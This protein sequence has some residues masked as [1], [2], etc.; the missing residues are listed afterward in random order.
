[1]VA[2]NEHQEREALRFF[3]SLYGDAALGFLPIWTRQD[4]ITRWLPAADLES[5]ARVVAHLART[6]DVYFGVGL[7]PRDLGQNRRGEGKL[8]EAIPALWA[9]SDVQGQAHKSTHLPP[10]K[11]DA[12]A[13]LGEF[14]LQPTIVVNS[15]H[16]LQSWWL[17]KE[18]WT[19]DGDEERRRAQD[20]V[21]RFQATLQAKA[22][23]RGWSIDNTSD[24]ARVMRPAGTWNHK[25]DPVPVHIIELDQK[26]R[27]APADFEPYLSNEVEVPYRH[28]ESVEDKIPEGRRNDTLFRRACSMRAQGFD[29]EAI[30]AAILN[31]NRTQCDPP[32]PENEVRRIAK[33]ASRYEPGP[34]A[35]FQRFMSEEPSRPPILSAAPKEGVAAES[36]LRVY[37]AREIAEIAP[38]EPEWLVRPYAV[39]GAITDINGK[40][41]ASGKTTFVTH[42]CRKVLEGEPFLD[43]PTTKTGVM[44]LSEQSAATF[45]EALSRA[46]LLDREDFAVVLWRDTIGLNWPEIVHEAA[47]EAV[48]RDANLLVIDTLP[49]FAGLKGDGENSATAALAAMAP[50][51]EVAA[52]HDLAVVIVRHERKSGG[53]V[54]DSGRGSSAFAGAV[55]LIVSIRR[56]E[57]NSRPNIRE[58][59]ALSRFDETPDV[60]AVELTEDD[61]YRALGDKAAVAESEAREAIL[62]AAPTSEAA[63]VNL[64]MLVMV[65]GLGRTTAQKAIDS[66]LEAGKLRRVGEG[67][68]GS[69]YRYWRPTRPED[70]P[71]KPAPEE[72]QMRSAATQ[73]LQAAERK[74]DVAG[75][76]PET[77]PAEPPVPAPSDTREEQEDDSPQTGDDEGGRE[78]WNGAVQK[79]FEGKNPPKGYDPT[80]P[81]VANVQWWRT[82]LVRKEE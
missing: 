57:G 32:L 36:K 17:F 35:V 44:Y 9:D 31:I 58:L 43:L 38:D 26:R 71:D 62:E 42:L 47:E 28:A 22:R 60:L 14:P 15:G 76:A 66:L 52:T 23:D 70:P 48:R 1:M 55:D 49:Q 11:D 6:R 5:A 63:A 46:G 75:E 19:F 2:Q 61:G 29:E 64:T 25:L 27:Y 37:T 33:S 68:K 51:Q 53:Q 24:L 12:R 81:A 20:L 34:W 7:Q 13:L 80:C 82:D 69:P 67:V 72:N 30:L 39:K 79:H 21:R 18:P 77:K 73:A 65:I 74:P 8:V 40:A 10:T 54:G 16:G 78:D 3:R 4:R 56:V 59:H 45:R 50:I 41:K